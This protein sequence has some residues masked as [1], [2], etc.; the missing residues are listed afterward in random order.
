MTDFSWDYVTRTASEALVQLG[1]SVADTIVQAVEPGIYL[2]EPDI[3][4]EV[5]ATEAGAIVLRNGKPVAGVD[6]DPSDID[7]ANVAVEMAGML[8]PADVCTS[9][10]IILAG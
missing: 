8:K 7:L 4:Y 1:R 5:R 6:V 2:V 10:Q 3:V 9:V